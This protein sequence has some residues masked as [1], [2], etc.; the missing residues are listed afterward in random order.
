MI[1]LVQTWRKG[2]HHPSRQGRRYAITFG[3]RKKK[4]KLHPLTMICQSFID[5][6]EK[7]SPGWLS[8]TLEKNQILRNILRPHLHPHYSRGIE[9]IA[10]PQK[11]G[12]GAA[13]FPFSIDIIMYHAC[14]IYIYLLNPTRNLW[15]DYSSVVPFYAV[16]PRFHSP[17]PPG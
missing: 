5:F 1:V 14:K 15:P 16:K 8:K 6:L 4:K 7:I 10:T 12:K 2:N 11:L 9:G 17:L 3:E 13:V